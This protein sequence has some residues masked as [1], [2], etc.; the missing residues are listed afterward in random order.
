MFYT[1]STA[2]KSM[3]TRFGV[4]KKT[5]H[6]ELRFLFLQH[7]VQAGVLTICRIADESNRADVFTKYVSAVVISRH[8]GRIGLH[9]R[10]T[11]HIIYS[12]LLSNNNCNN[13]LYGMFG[14]WFEACVF[15]FVLIVLIV[16]MFASE[17]VLDYEDV[18]IAS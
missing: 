14:N 7:L 10:T 6:G 18:L 2:G 8:V 11:R 16:L 12:M 17:L 13:M 5:R 15:Y 4:S 3:A 9:A 1:D